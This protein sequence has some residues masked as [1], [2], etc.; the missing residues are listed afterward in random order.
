MKNFMFSI[1]KFLTLR[2]D[3]DNS[4]GKQKYPKETKIQ[5]E[6]ICVLGISKL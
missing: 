6:N 4:L 5:K 3:F 1:A 2:V